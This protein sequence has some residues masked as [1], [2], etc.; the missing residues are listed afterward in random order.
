[1]PGAPPPA[2][3][4]LPRRVLGPLQQFVQ[5]TA[6]GATAL[7]VAAAAA[8]VWANAAPDSYADVWGAS[9]RLSVGGLD[10][11]TSV[12]SLVKNGLMAVFFLVVGLEIKRELTVGE[13]QDRRVAVLPVFAALGGMLLPA[14]IYAAVNAGGE[15]IHGWGIPMA[16]DIAFAVGALHL[17]GSRIP[18]QL[19]A[20]LLGLAVID[21]IGAILVIAVFYS[22]DLNPLALGL[23]VLALACVAGLVRARV[24]LLTP[25]VVLG[26]CAWAAMWASG[27]SPTIAAVAFGLLMPVRPPRSPVAAAD[28]ARE[29][30]DD[31]E[32]GHHDRE[33]E[34]ESWR[35]IG[36]LGRDGVPMLLRMEHALTPWS[37]F[38]VLPVFA[39]AFAGI[40]IDAET[41][42]SALSSRITWGV[43]LGLVVGKAVGVTLGT[44]IAVVTR[45]G[46]LPD[47]VDWARVVGVGGLAGI[48]FT[49]SIYVATL[50]FTDTAQ[51]ADAKLGILAASIVAGGVGSIALLLAGR[52]AA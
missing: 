32:R 4:P 9:V 38:V 23:A 11:D 51:L 49:V 26:L 44:W 18:S 50:A 47:Q 31:L 5:T 2:S 24:V 19:A 45:A 46:R 43:L 39:L 33:L 41:V 21:D 37:S 17:L 35:E 34:E 29:I 1:M 6:A 28:R 22:G 13:L 10:L 40:R 25:Y 27:V 30:A 52:R 16:T 15:G 3:L 7:L 20:F 36:R 48:G 14:V 12:S 42:S 8:L